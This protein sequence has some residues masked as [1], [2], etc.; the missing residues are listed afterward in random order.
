MRAFGCVLTAV[1]AAAVLTGGPS[2]A[3]ARAADTG[4]A[5]CTGLFQAN[6]PKGLGAVADRVAFTNEGSFD[7]RGTVRGAGVTGPGRLTETGFVDGSCAAGTVT[8]TVLLSIPTEDGE[9]KLRVPI[10]AHYTGA[11]GVRDVPS[12]PGGFVIRPTAGDCVTAPVTGVE[13]YFYGVLET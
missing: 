7:C 6:I 3:S 11:L 13:V 1:T 2:V 8:S 12:L 10:K 4:R 9:V 5:V